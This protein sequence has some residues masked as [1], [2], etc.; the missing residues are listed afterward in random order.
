[1]P[2]T[3]PSDKRLE[4]FLR[5][6]NVAGAAHQSALGDFYAFSETGDLTA[7]EKARLDA[8]ANLEAH[9]DAVLAAGIEIRKR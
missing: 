7:A 3:R 5:T 2:K 9:L 6:A 1:M 8:V 4:E